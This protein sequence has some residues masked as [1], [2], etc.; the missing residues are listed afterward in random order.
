MEVAC[1]LVVALDSILESIKFQS[2]LQLIFF[3][4]RHA[5]DPA[6]ISAIVI[7]LLSH[8]SLTLTRVTSMFLRVVKIFSH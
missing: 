7:S 2:N 5:V 6:S 1:D 3:F 4:W 8:V